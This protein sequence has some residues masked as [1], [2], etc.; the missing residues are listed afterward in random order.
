MMVSF[1][2]IEWYWNVYRVNEIHLKG[3]GTLKAAIHWLTVCNTYILPKWGHWLSCAFFKLSHKEVCCEMENQEGRF[4]A[5]E[6]REP[7]G[8]RQC[9]WPSPWEW[10]I[11][12]ERDHDSQGQGEQQGSARSHALDRVGSCSCSF[13]CRGPTSEE[14][15]SCRYLLQG[16]AQKGSQIASVGILLMPATLGWMFPLWSPPRSFFPR[17]WVLEGRELCCRWSFSSGCVVSKQ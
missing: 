16:Q 15:F 7:S 6:S 14:V 10:E 4:S 1:H 13:H 12:V 11:T 17:H 3:H 5:L 9:P 8:Q 2:P